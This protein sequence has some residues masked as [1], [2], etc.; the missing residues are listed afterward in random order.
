MFILP[1]F[2]GKPQITVHALGG[3][4]DV[5]KLLPGKKDALFLRHD[6]NRRVVKT[7]KPNGVSKG[8]VCRPAP[9]IKGRAE[10]VGKQRGGDVP[11]THGQKDRVRGHLQDVPGIDQRT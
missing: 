7:P 6:R 5:R 4:G 1:V 3:L 10:L 8:I 2:R 9:L 11:F